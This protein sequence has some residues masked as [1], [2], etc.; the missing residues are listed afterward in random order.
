MAGHSENYISNYAVI[1]APLYQLSRKDTKFKWEKEEEK[2]FRK[3]QDSISNDKT[4]AFFYPS[5]PIILRTEA[6]YNQVLLAALLQKTDKGIPS[7]FHLSHDDR[8]REKI[9][10]PRKMY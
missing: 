3:I 10:R 9:A 5:R 2:V 4:M 1:A 8:N 7:T 6:S